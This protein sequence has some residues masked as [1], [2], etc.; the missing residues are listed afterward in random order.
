M[1]NKLEI[2]KGIAPG[3]VI[4]HELLKK[5]IT[6]RELAKRINAHYQTINAIVMGRRKLTTDLALKIEDALGFPEGF[7]LMLQVYYDIEQ[8]KN[9]KMEEQSATPN[10]RPIIFWDTDY[11]KIDW[12]RHKRA[13]INR[14]LERGNQAE[15]EELTRFYKLTAK[16]IDNYKYK[17]SYRIHSI[18]NT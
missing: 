13:I 3:S 2:L 9:P 8:H 1:Q 10:I 11:E 15:I 14:V 12:A 16:D 4:E 18:R 7:L 5:D 17:N 6:Q